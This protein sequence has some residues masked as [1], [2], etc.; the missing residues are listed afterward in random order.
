MYKCKNISAYWAG[1]PII[2]MAVWNN[3]NSARDWDGVENIFTPQSHQKGPRF[4]SVLAV[5]HKAHN[6]C[7]PWCGLDANGK[8]QAVQEVYIPETDPGT[9]NFFAAVRFPCRDLDPGEQAPTVTNPTNANTEGKVPP[10][11]KEED[12]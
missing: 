9:D 5:I 12:Q 10:L 11:K 7:T 4:Q 6:F 2:A 3:T 1:S 8:W